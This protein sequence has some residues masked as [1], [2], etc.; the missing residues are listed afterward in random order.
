[1][2]DASD[3]LP[4]LTG[5]ELVALSKAARAGAPAPAPTVE[6]MKRQAQALKTEM[7]SRGEAAKHCHCLEA[8]ARAYGY[9]T[10]ASALVSAPSQ[11]EGT[12]ARG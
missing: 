7:R 8:V 12:P 10:W 2:P 5:A 11:A 9:R 1:M 6:A 4:R 3:A